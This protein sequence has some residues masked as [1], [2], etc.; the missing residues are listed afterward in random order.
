MN[1]AILGT[2]NVWSENCYVRA[3]FNTSNNTKKMMF[4]GNIDLEK[5]SINDKLNL[6]RESGYEITIGKSKENET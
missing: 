6:W 3:V 5:K 1:S 4:L 2:I